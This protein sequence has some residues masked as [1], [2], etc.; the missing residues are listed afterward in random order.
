MKI[1]FIIDQVYLHGGI[2]RVLSIK[3][4]YF[5]SLDTHQVYI[6]T[7]E[8]RNKKACY[9]FN[10]QIVFCD[11]NI[12]YVRSK[13]YFHP[14]NLLKSLK[15]LFKLRRKLK[16]I[17]PDVVVVC[18]HST[19]TH[20]VPFMNRNIPK[21]K[22]FHYS[23]HIEEHKRSQPGISFKKLFFALTDYVESKYDALV[24]LNPDELKYYKTNNVKIIP[25]PNTFFPNVVSKVSNKTV[26]T[27]GRI[28]P[29]KG[30]DRLIDIWALVN[31]QIPD[32]QLH[33]YGDGNAE[34]IKMLEAKIIAHGLTDTLQLKGATN[35]IEKV[36]FEASI[37]AM[38]SHNECFPLVL[39][40]AQASGLPIIS[41]D[42]PHGPRNIINNHNGILIPVHDNEAFANSL[43]HLMLHNEL[44][45]SMGKNA[46]INAN[47]FNV[48]KVMA[49]W[50]EMFNEVV[51]D[52]N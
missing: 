33:I 3:A 17:N 38:T 44:L 40:E 43:I 27:A 13:S 23:K 10:N 1:V 25:N 9:P 15:H 21:I 50:S 32:W 52:K 22:E 51:L 30:Y 6:I 48:E 2:E 41:F 45:I 36:F 14:I 8:Q 4:N 12:N 42:C 24:I 34:Y 47:N 49:L 29:V 19:D 18:S 16:E 46:R 37:F 20:F 26:V 31:K 5:S 7:T 39:L 11:L 35:A 28:A